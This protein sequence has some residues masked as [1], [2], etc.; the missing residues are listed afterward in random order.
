MERECSQAG[1][2]LET[3]LAGWRGRREKNPDQRVWT[4]EEGAE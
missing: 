1:V 4:V 3:M 2:D